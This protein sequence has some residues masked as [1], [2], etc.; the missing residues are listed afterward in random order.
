MMVLD[1]PDA[2]AQAAAEWMLTALDRPGAL[3]VAL[4]GGST[5]QRL[6]E[7]L[8]QPPHRDRMPWERVHWFLGDE[9]LVSHDD[10]QSNYRMALHAMLHLAPATNIHPV[11]IEGLTATEAAA[12]YEAEL[13]AY[14]NTTLDTPLFDVVLMG[15]GADGHTA[16]LFPGAPA[17]SNRTDWA[18]AVTRPDGLPGVTLTYPALESCR[19]AAFLVAGTDKRDVLAQVRA[20]EAGLPAAGYKPQGTLRWFVDRAA[21]PLNTP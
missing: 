11:P 4:S 3:A 17:L 15:L 8:A 20:G 16:S 12:R 18:V 10:P 2:L 5:P 19:H 6:Y 14:H 9:R 13:Q 21:A 1:T 7:A